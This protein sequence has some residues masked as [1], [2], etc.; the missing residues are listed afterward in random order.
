MRTARLPSVRVLVATN[1]CQFHWGK[2]GEGTQVPCPGVSS[3]ACDLFND[4][5]ANPPTPT[6][7]VK[8]QMPMKTNFAAGSE[9]EK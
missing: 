6:Q 4:A 8:R 3:L 7:I 2:G 1:M 9:N 5:F